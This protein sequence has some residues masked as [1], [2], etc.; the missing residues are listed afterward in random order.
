VL[1]QAAFRRLPFILETPGF[2]GT[3]PD[4][5]NMRALRRLAL[6]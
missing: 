1:R 2:D 6:H 5:R 3:G 4:R